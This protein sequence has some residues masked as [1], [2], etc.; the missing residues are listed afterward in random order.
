M[1][2]LEASLPVSAHHFRRIS[3]S[4]VTEDYTKDGDFLDIPHSL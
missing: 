3:E 2:L 1:K 4:P